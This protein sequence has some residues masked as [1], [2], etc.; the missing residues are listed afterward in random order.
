MLFGQQAKISV[1]DVGQYAYP[2]VKLKDKQVADK[3]NNS[4]INLVLDTAVYNVGNI[5]DSMRLQTKY[6]YA[7]YDG[8]DHPYLLDG[9][10]EI[11]HDVYYNDN[12]LLSLELHPVYATAY[13]TF[14]NK[15]AVFNINNGNMLVFDEVVDSNTASFSQCLY[16]Y[17]KS[18][19]DSFFIKG[20]STYNADCIEYLEDNKDDI[21]SA[22]DGLRSNTGIGTAFSMNK[23]GLYYTI[24]AYY[25]P[26]ALQACSIVLDVNISWKELVPN[27]S[28]K[29][30]LY[31]FTK[32]YR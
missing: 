18:K 19:V 16:T 9:M 17:V 10:A 24:S 31:P 29:S 12:G 28:T 20:S 8:V 14:D 13:I 21:Y 4:L 26:H 11:T 3:I 30:P 5:K 27:V 32:Q 22:V 23:E 1:I 7:K 2:V 6:T 15:P 25:F